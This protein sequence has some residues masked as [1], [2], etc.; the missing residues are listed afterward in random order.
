MKNTRVVITG[1]GIISSIGN[2]TE[3]FWQSLMD[4]KSGIGPITSFDASEYRTKIAGEVKDFN[5]GDYMPEK[6]GRK[7]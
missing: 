4:V 7:L 3:E 6:E 2:S 1:T 5:I